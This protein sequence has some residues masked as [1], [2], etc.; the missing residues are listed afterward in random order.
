M[1]GVNI[2]TVTDSPPL[3]IVEEPE[4]EAKPDIK[5]K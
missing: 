2:G 3:D 5:K 4:I 1:P